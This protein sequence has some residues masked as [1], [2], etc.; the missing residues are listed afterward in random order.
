MESV[1]LS[2]IAHC[3]SSTLTIW[4]RTKSIFDETVIFWQI[5]VDQFVTI[6]QIWNKLGPIAITGTIYDKF[7]F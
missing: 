3:G 1:G 6:A 4:R 7:N 5:I 2:H